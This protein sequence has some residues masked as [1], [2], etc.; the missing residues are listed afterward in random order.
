MKKTIILLCGTL[1]FLGS[2][3]QSIRGIVKDADENTLSYVN[4]VLLEKNQSTITNNKGLFKFTNLK[5]GIYHLQISFVGM[6]T[7]EKLT[8][9]ND[10]VSVDLGEIIM[11]NA[12]FKTQEVV[13]TATKTPRLLNSIPATI[14][15]ISQLEINVIPSQ[16]IDEKLKYTAGVLVDRPFG[17]FGKSAISMRGVV[18]SEPGRQ[19]TLV[20][21]VPINK[22]DGG[23]VNWNRI[24]NS[25]IE[26]IE[27]TKGPSSSIYGSNAM[28]GTINLITKRPKDKGVSGSA[29]IFYGKYNTLG[30]G[31]NLMHKFNDGSKGFYYALSGKYL[32][33]DGYITVPDSI[34]QDTDTLVFVKEQAANARLGYLFS[35]STFVELEYNYYDDHRGQGSKI[36]LEEGSTAD[37]DTHFI[38]SKYKT[39]IG[40]FYIDLNGFY[41][42][43]SYLR[44]AE[45]EKNG[46]YTLY[47]VRSDRLDYGMLSSINTS[48]R[49]HNLSLGADYR[50]GSV[51]GIDEYQ[52]STDRV[53]N[54][55][56]INH[57]NIFFQDQIRITDNIRSIVAVQYAFSHFYNGA[58]TIEEP[59]NV[60]SF[61]IAD[62][63]SLTEKFWNGFS[64]SISL[65]YDLS[66]FLN[67]YSI[68]SS[69]FRAASLDDMT[70]TGFINIGYKQA[71][72]NLTP[73]TIN[74][75]E[76]GSRF[77][78]NKIHISANT[79]YS[80]G[81]DFMHYIATGETLFGGKK[82]IYKKQNIS[83]VEIY[84][85]EANVKY[86]FNKWI[87]LGVN[88]SHNKSIIKRFDKRAD[89]ENKI[90]TY[91]PQNMF[92]IITIIKNKKWLS[93]VNIHWQDKLFLDEENTFVIDALIGLDLR[94]SYRFFN[95][96]GAGINVQ[97]VLNEQHMVSS[98]Q[99]SLGRFFTFELN[100]KF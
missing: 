85:T 50:N 53:I 4:V 78:K 97:N 76:L 37:F 70:R 92:N 84:G 23:G 7:I 6:V 88:Y 25:D 59:T 8:L 43:E 9:I 38:K 29:K 62:I 42:L 26:H 67:I 54:Q 58:F 20:D 27:I 22:S 55:G 10:G 17:I 65:Q 98:D 21:G 77:T 45:K 44:T 94:L 72:S 95:G 75:V 31:F 96:F 82:I 30:S 1:A 57:I 47:H 18:S 51:H 46:D 81:Y 100:Y 35:N 36:K 24:I 66:E 71:N 32:E 87:S 80:R 89:L 39:K 90:L 86:V 28:G 13:V 48:F 49:N 63:G 61:M 64:P 68:A 83:D 60:T 40:Q 19:L 2:V 69:G 11:L 79:Y 3:A 33:S 73:E 12:S 16:K 56:E 15:Y 34:R 14:E 5:D 41:Q 93:S 52:T 91:S 74:N 99:V